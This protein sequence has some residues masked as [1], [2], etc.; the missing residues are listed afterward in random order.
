M[1]KIDDMELFIIVVKAGGL[2]VA[3]RQIGLSPASM[4][5][6][7]NAPEK[8]YNTRLLQRTTRRISLTVAGSCSVDVRWFSLER[9]STSFLSSAHILIRFW[10]RINLFIL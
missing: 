1:S 8:R 10:Q 9:I 4:T 7:I 5:S 3:G 2:A 6:R